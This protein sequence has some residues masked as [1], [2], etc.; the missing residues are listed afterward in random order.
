MDTKIARERDKRRRAH[1]T[2]KKRL[3]RC[4]L[5]VFVA[6]GCCLAG[7]A[8]SP[9]K[10]HPRT[11]TDT[12]IS[13]LHNPVLKGFYPDPSIIR[14]GRPQDAGADYYLVN[15]TFS[16]FPGIPVFHSRDMVHWT[17]IGN[18]ITRP[19]QMN[20]LGAGVSRGL[21]AP[22][23]SFYDGVFYLVCTQVDTGGNFVVTAKDP[24]GPWSDP[25]F[26]PQVQGIDP[27]LYFDPGTGKAYMIGR[28]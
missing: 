4:L 1:S 24:A 25:V 26:L 10:M 7:G 27:S 8:Q 5:L 9:V 22:S 6:Q 21:F 28:E 18:V 17:Q 11:G 20:F 3:R 23:I 16:Y 13:V 2:C 19:A 15:S 14:V 12:G